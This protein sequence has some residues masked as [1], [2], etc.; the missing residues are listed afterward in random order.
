L[1]GAGGGEEKG[2]ISVPSRVFPGDLSLTAASKA[3]WLQE[4]NRFEVKPRIQISDE[5]RTVGKH[6]LV[7]LEMARLEGLVLEA[8]MYLVVA[9]S[10]RASAESLLQE[11]VRLLSGFGAFRSRGYGRGRVTLTPFEALPAPQVVPAPQ[12]GTLCRYSLTALVH[13]RNKPVDPGNAQVI[14]T[15]QSISP[16]QVKGWLARAFQARHGRWP[17]PAQMAGVRLS[18]LYPSPGP[19]LLAWPSPLTTLKDQD[20]RIKDTWGDKPQ[21]G[22]ERENGF[23]NGKA[24]PLSG[25]TV[26]EEGRAHP[27]P[28]FARMRNAMDERFVTT[29]N[30]LFA[31]AF[32]PA[33]TC[34]TGTVELAAGL[35]DAF[36]GEVLALLAGATPAINGALFA[37]ALDSRVC[38]R[39]GADTDKPELLAS[40]R[41]LT[42]DLRLPG[43]GLTIATMRGY[44]TECKRPRRGRVVVMP[45]S[46]L[47]GGEART[48]WPGFCEGH[49][50]LQ[51]VAVGPPDAGQQDVGGTPSATA[52]DIELTEKQKRGI[53]RAQAG[54]LR[55]MLH[56]A[57]TA[58]ALGK[59]LDHRIVKY[60]EKGKNHD[61]LALLQ[62]IKAILDTKDLKAMRRSVRGVL[63]QLALTYWAQ[64]NK[65]TGGHAEEEVNHADA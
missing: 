23:F 52:P 59:E 40:P 64:R 8:P 38:P 4:K 42:R 51:D 54:Q 6:F 18:P 15:A 16:E 31:Q 3:I 19:H 24:T 2:K 17:S 26:T 29:L 36:K 46:T 35:E 32:L 13:V 63:E 65:Q 58:E 62:S 55:A 14:A 57:L 39:F 28:T 1:F 50:V 56:P 5:T 27:A 49:R 25:Y 21:E 20:D 34:F 37:P 22:E 10:Q 33:G 7:D 41:P 43:N 48:P 60:Q 44:N 12:S 53:G 11:A 45:G 30:G 9:P 61:L 47:L